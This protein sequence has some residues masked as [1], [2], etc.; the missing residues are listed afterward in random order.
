MKKSS[1]YLSLLILLVLGLSG[2]VSLGRGSHILVSDEQ[3]WTIPKGTPFTAT[4]KPTVPEP[5][6]FQVDNSDLKVVYPGKLA[7]LQEEANENAFKMAEKAKT[8]GLVTG[9]ISA[10]LGMFLILL[11]RWG[12]KKIFS[13]IESRGKKKK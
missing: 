8:R 2:C 1:I 4:Q 3:M 7:D 9:G 6:Q 5:Q 13:S 12:A 11:G 10:F